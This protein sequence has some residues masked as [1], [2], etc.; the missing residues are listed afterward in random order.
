MTLSVPRPDTQLGCPYA[1][2]PLV[3]ICMF[4]F[5]L[6]QSS[7]PKPLSAPSL[8]QLPRASSQPSATSR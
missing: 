3:Q 1:T 8:P 2:V 7:C 6:V 5:Q 4:L